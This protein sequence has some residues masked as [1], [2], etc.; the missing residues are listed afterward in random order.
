PTERDALGRLGVS[1][2]VEHFPAGGRLPNAHRLVFSG[3]GDA[4]AVGAEGDAEDESV[5]PL[6][7]AEPLAARRVP[8]EQGPV[9][10][11]RDELPTVRT[12]RQRAD[13]WR[14]SD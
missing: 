13:G 6:E 11:G 3:R 14:C 2:E 7:G 9:E 8:H 4:R 1:A 5:V 10:A 12:E